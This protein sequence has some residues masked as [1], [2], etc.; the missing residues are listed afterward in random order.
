MSDRNPWQTLHSRTVYQNAWIR[1]REDQVTRPDGTPGIYGVVELKPSIGVVV[2]NDADQIALV[3]QWRY[4]HGRFSWEIPTGGSCVGDE[5]I[6]D[7][8][9][10]ELVEE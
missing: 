4:V 2:L 9:R 8:A 3:G 6:L 7:A 1:V 5:T 10:R